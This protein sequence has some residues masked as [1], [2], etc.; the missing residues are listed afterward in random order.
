MVG[1]PI[2]YT[3]REELTTF[4]YFLEIYTNSFDAIDKNGQYLVVW[5]YKEKETG[6]E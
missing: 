3:L 1:G 5:K 2:I 6:K 4:K